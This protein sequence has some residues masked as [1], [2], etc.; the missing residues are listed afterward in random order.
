MFKGISDISS[1]GSGIWMSH[2]HVGDVILKF[3]EYDRYPSGVAEK[4]MKKVI[5]IERHRG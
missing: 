2:I 5:M 1:K 3:T 4:I